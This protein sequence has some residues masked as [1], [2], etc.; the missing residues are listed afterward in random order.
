MSSLNSL[1][2]VQKKAVMDTEGPV[3]VFAGAGSGKTRVLTNRI[4]YLIEE[5]HINP[6]NIL[7][8]TFTNKA[9]KEMMIRLSDALGDNNN[10]NISTMHTLC[11]TM[12]HACAK[13]IGYKPNFTIYDEVA[14]ARVIKSVIKENLKLDLSNAKSYENHISKCK[15]SGLSIDKYIEKVFI[16][17]DIDE[18]DLRYVYNRYNELLKE[19]NALDF[20]DLLLKT[21]ELLN[22]S[23]SDREYYQNKY[24][25]IHV[26]EFQDTN[27]LQLEIIRIL[28]DKWKNIFVVGDDD[29]SIYSWRGAEIKNILNFSKYFENAK[30]YKL[31]QNYR[32]YQ[33]ILDYSNNLIKNNSDRVDKTL[34]SKIEDDD[35][36]EPKVKFISS[37]NE[38]DEVDNILNLIYSLKAKGYKNRDIAILVRNNYST[39]AFEACFNS[40]GINYKVYGAYKFFDREE[41][42]NMAAY[43][44]MLVNPYDIDSCTRVI[45]FPPRGIGSVT[46]DK[47]VE[48][49]RSGNKSIIEVIMDIENSGLSKNIIQKIVPFRDLLNDL[50]IHNKTSNILDF[51]RY[52]I[53]ATG[54]DNFYKNSKD[55]EMIDKWQNIEQFVNLVSNEYQKNNAITLIEFV[56]SLTLDNGKEN[57]KDDYDSDDLTI[58]TMHSVKGLEYSVVIIASCEENIIP[59]YY[60]LLEDNVEEERRVMY[61]A[62]T[63]AR[64]RLYI[65]YVEGTRLKFGQRER[66]MQSRFVA[67]AKGNK[68]RKE[69]LDVFNSNSGGH[70]G[71]YSGGGN[72]KQFEQNKYSD[73]PFYSNKQSDN[74]K[75]NGY[76]FTSKDKELDSVGE[77][78]NNYDYEQQAKSM[79][80]SS[81][82][83]NN[84]VDDDKFI[85][86]AKVKH[87]RYGIGTIKEVNGTGIGKTV[88]VFFVGLG[89]KKFAVNM[90]MLTIVDD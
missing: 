85:Q 72:L 42:R 10:V 61:V 21:V 8:I 46:I 55:P 11:S 39:S 22:V 29:Q 15:N 69:V 3:L 68:L 75:Y 38:Y 65:S 25:Y 88:T 5:K 31:E 56:N 83:V 76:G 78:R 87:K 43:L 60:A 50:F 52:L 84:N 57:L 59:S 28:S 40:N 20:D 1:N 6:W 81:T 18:N 17:N 90:G 9:T 24:K 26:D 71:H 16:D 32:S 47:L 27:T 34:F 86:G 74:D 4:I 70:N 37:S 58:A 7:A 36:D 64:E 66:T 51:V 41:I 23:D 30:I 67:E 33:E 77:D 82:Q 63:R 48:C 45:N 53:S 19:S 79:L 49:V 13:K 14:S 62:M 12:L 54:I 2:E 89:F 44:R 35:K 73:N 80:Q